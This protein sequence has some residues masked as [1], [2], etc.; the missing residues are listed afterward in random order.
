MKRRKARN[1]MFR[2]ARTMESTFQF[3][4][5]PRIWQKRMPRVPATAGTAANL[6]KM[7]CSGPGYSTILEVER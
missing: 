5:A 3:T 1:G 6:K 7:Q 4:A 2:D